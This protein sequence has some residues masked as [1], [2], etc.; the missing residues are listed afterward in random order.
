MKIVNEDFIFVLGLNL[1]CFFTRMHI[2]DAWLSHHSIKNDAERSRQVLNDIMQ[3][4]PE[5][6]NLQVGHIENRVSAICSRVSHLWKQVQRSKVRLIAKYRDWLNETESCVLKTRVL[7]EVTN[8]ASPSTSGHQH[9]KEFE[10]CSKRTKRRRLAELAKV[11]DSAVHALLNNSNQPDS[12]SLEFSADQVVSLFIEAKLTKHQYLLLRDFIHSKLPNVLPSYQKVLEA[13]KQCYPSGISVTES[14]AEIDLQCLLDHTCSRILESQKSVLENIP[15]SSKNEYVLVGKWGFDGSTGHSEYKQS[16]SDSKI[17]DGSLIVTSYA[18]LQLICKST[19]SDS[20]KIIWKNPRS[21][22]TRFC[23][24]IRFQFAKETKQLSVLEEEHFKKA[25]SNLNPTVV[26]I[27]TRSFEVSH[28][29]QLTM[30]DGKV[31]C[32]LSDSSASKCY[33][34]GATPKEM[35]DLEKCTNKQVD[36]N[37]FQFG[38]SPLHSWIRFFE[39]FIHISYRIEIRRWQ[40]R[41]PEDKA[42]LAKKRNL[43]KSSLGN[44]WV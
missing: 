16:F 12:N 35:N 28:S 3:A 32:A 9:R 8:S 30:V 20:D 2:L 42:L 24:P 6:E 4:L 36:P 39:Y 7:R 17:E 44:A 1:K 23:R 25:I 5:A 27:D 26:N 22:S 31:C 43:F 14:T 41:S 13:K 11:D 34:C 10:D 38:L 21:S 29:L 19:T 15:D 40:A 18:P 33:I 37:R